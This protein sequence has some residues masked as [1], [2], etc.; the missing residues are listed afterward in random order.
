MSFSPPI[1]A[2]LFVGG[3]IDAKYRRKSTKQFAEKGWSHFSGLRLLPSGHNELWNADQIIGDDG[4]EEIGGH[5][6]K[7]AMFDPFFRK[8]LG[9]TRHRSDLPLVERAGLDQSK[10][11]R[12]AI[13]TKFIERVARGH[14]I[15]TPLPFEHDLHGGQRAVVL[16]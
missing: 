12:P 13:E 5:A 1:E 7:A 11:K 8:L 6:M 4:D 9:V 14:G 10:H 3:T 15:K 2:R 16:D